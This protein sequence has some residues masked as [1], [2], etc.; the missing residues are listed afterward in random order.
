MCRVVQQ[1]TTS[2]GCGEVGR[3]QNSNGASKRGGFGFR[4]LTQRKSDATQPVVLVS[5]TRRPSY[6]SGQWKPFKW[7]S[8]D[9]GEQR[10]ASVG[11][12]GGRPE[13]HQLTDVDLRKR[14]RPEAAAATSVV[15]E[16]R[17]NEAFVPDRL[18]H[19]VW[20]ALLRGRI[21]EGSSGFK[22]PDPP[23]PLHHK[24]KY[25]SHHLIIPIP[26]TS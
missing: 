18:Q 12:G 10:R 6:N 21:W 3:G 19:D 22:I 4:Q 16:G 1:R 15:P 9:C 2:N 17:V 26:A 23:I 25:Y 14:D 13:Q 11:G 24:S 5:M 20:C 8:S 7:K